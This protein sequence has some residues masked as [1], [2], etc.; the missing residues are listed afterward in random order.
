MHKASVASVADPPQG[1]A[2]RRERDG[3]THTLLCI[4]RDPTPG[5]RNV[6]SPAPRRVW[7]HPSLQDHYY[8]QATTGPDGRLGKYESELCLVLEE[9]KISQMYFLSLPWQNGLSAF[10]YPRV[11]RSKLGRL[12]QPRGRSGR[13]RTGVKCAPTAAS[14]VGYLLALLHRVFV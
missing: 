8:Y 4:T 14:A 13:P 3:A 6:A 2:I 5:Y 7:C 9:M 1:V 11:S 10:V 12:V